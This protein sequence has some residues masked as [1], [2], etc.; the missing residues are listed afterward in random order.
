MDV[1]GPAEERSPL[2]GMP[3]RQPPEKPI[4]ADI[5][6]LPSLTSDLDAL[7]Y[8]RRRRWDGAMSDGWLR[9]S[10]L[11]APILS[12]RYGKPWA[13]W[14]RGFRVGAHLLGL[15]GE[16]VGVQLRNIWVEEGDTRRSRFLTL[17]RV[18]TFGD[19]RIIS[20][21]RRVIVVEGLGGWISAL[22]WHS[23]SQ[24]VLGVPG[25]STALELFRNVN[26]RRGMEVLLAFDND[27]AGS[28]AEAGLAKLL[29]ERGAN[30]MRLQ[31]PE[32]K[33]AHVG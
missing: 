15:D 23:S 12:D 28:E 18:G 4:P 9:F 11:D 13:A 10:T 30:P 32:A 3:L 27:R 16:V 7:A 5:H 20:E 21:A 26:F 19:R 31:R 1:L 14:E 2:R 29:R 6:D 25:T 33:A 17:G 8:L 24:P 22:K